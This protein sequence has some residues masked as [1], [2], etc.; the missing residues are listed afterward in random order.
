MKLPIRSSHRVARRAG[1]PRRGFL[2]ERMAAL[3]RFLGWLALTTGL[4]TCAGQ[5][6]TR[7]ASSPRGDRNGAGPAAVG[8][9]VAAGA[10]GGTSSVAGGLGGAAGGNAAG[11]SGAAGG[12]RREPMVPLLPYPAEPLDAD[13]LRTLRQRLSRMA[14]RV[15]PGARAAGDDIAGKLG[16][17]QRLERSYVVGKGC[18]TAVGLAEAGGI[19]DLGLELALVNEAT[20]D[21]VHADAGKGDTA[22]VGE[23]PACLRVSTGGE[24]RL[25]ITA[26]SGAG[27]AAA[28]L[29]GR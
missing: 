12:A 10:S 7:D 26:L 25:M 9:L 2:T 20:P 3:G 13:A 28:Q 19:I 21:R 29:Y 14:A 6:P 17:G 1:Q 22:V 27:L 18:Y 23:P 16:T 24:L 5:P 15:A 4:V 8:D 11:E